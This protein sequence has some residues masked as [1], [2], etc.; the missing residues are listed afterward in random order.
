MLPEVAG[1]CQ[2]IRDLIVFLAPFTSPRFKCC[3]KGGA[4]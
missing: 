1:K 2:F 3:G 4:L